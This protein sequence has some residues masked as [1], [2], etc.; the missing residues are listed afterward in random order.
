MTRNEDV[1]NNPRGGT[2]ELP[3]RNEVAE[4][5]LACRTSEKRMNEARS[6]I[7]QTA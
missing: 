3:Y 4:Q 2:L 5:R 6:A 1:K 7:I